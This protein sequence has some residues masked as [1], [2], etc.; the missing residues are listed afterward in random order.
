MSKFHFMLFLILLTAFSTAI[1]EQPFIKG[2]LR[3]R[4]GNQMFIV[5][6]NVS[7]ALDNGAR[8]IFPEFLSRKDC[9]IPTNYKM[10]F[11]R[12]DVNPP[13]SEISYSY[14]EPSFLYSPI[15]YRPNMETHGWFASERHFKHHKK[16]IQQ[17]FAPHPSIVDYLKSKYPAIIEHPYT[18]AV[19]VRAYALESS[20]ANKNF[21]SYGADYFDRAMSLF[22][23][24]TLFVVFSD[25]IKWCKKK[26]K[27][28]SKKRNIQFIENEISVHD[29]YLMSMCKHNIISNSTFSWWGAYLN[30]N[31]DK[32]VI[33]P[34]Q[35][36]TQESSLQEI[37]DLFP[38]EWV[39]LL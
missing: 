2:N 13:D 33:A 36:F 32:V 30:E 20:Y 19:H 1:A 6:A 37:P 27:K 3:E 23:E 28:I 38:E 16:E 17:L 34:P 24:G 35:W 11:W 5:A 26:F 9:D 15:P 8:A 7:L 12:L 4:L 31:P 25:K 29:L 18:V 22:P 21:V 39:I 14:Q 10:V